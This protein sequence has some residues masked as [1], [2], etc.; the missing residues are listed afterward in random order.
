MISADSAFIG[1]GWGRGP[2]GWLGLA[3]AVCTLPWPGFVADDVASLPPAAAARPAGQLRADP[4]EIRS[5]GHRA[6]TR[7]NHPRL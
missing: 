4:E 7:T 3:V 1:P 2:A 5:C 6:K